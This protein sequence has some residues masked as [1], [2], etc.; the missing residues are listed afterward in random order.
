[1][2]LKPWMGYARDTEHEVAKVRTLAF[3]ERGVLT[4]SMHGRPQVS[5]GYQPRPSLKNTDG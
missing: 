1:M 5:A 2:I 4:A 3:V